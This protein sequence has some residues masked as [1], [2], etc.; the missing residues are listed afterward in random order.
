MS[1]SPDTIRR[2]RPGP[3]A[4]IAGSDTRPA[5]RRAAGGPGCGAAAAA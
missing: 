1:A 2:T 4:G 5:G 3:L